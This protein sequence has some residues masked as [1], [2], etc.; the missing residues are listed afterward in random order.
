MKS[1]IAYLLQIALCA[2]LLIIFFCAVSFTDRE[3]IKEHKQYVIIKSLG[4]ERKYE[5]D[6]K[7]VKIVEEV[8]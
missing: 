8:E 1:L 5:V 3:P 4:V 7:S 6:G 2:F